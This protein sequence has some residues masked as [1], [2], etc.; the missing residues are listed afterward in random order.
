M[1][2]IKP[3][4]DESNE[5]SASAAKIVT[6][7][8]EA[9]KNHAVRSR[10]LSFSSPACV[11][12][13][14]LTNYHVSKAFHSDKLT[15]SIGA[16]F[17][18]SLQA[19]AEEAG[20]ILKSAIAKMDRSLKAALEAGKKTASEA[21]EVFRKEI[22]SIVKAESSGDE[23]C[24]EGETPATAEQEGKLN[25]ESGDKDAVMKTATMPPAGEKGGDNSIESGGESPKSPASG[26][27]KTRS[28]RLALSRG[29]A[30]VRT[31]RSKKVNADVS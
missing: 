4:S 8:T 29:I 10:E 24:N 7:T 6:T 21:N 27:P 5:M 28:N 30:K 14:D 17:A 3:L 9:L 26:K 12:P 25:P 11:P 13:N 19:L 22:E 23:V 15:L 31:V 16:F 18:L 20:E 1:A 2:S